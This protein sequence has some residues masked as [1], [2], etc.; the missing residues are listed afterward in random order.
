M[1][2]CFKIII[3]SLINKEN[4]LKWNNIHKYKGV[5]KINNNNNNLLSIGTYF[6]RAERIWNVWPTLI[7]WMQPHPLTIQFNQSTLLVPI[8]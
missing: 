8:F 5:D 7:I 4:G 1:Q 3:R 6:M 2:L